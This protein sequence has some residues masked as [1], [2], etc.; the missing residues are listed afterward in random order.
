[1]LEA[2]LQRV[3]SGFINVF[4]KTYYN[5]KVLLL[6][7]RII[8]YNLYNDTITLKV[9]LLKDNAKSYLAS[10]SGA[11]F[12]NVL[13]N[14]DTF[15]RIGSFITDEFGNAVF[16]YSTNNIPR[17][18]I[19]TSQFYATVDYNASTFSSTLVRVNFIK[20]SPVDL[21]VELL[22]IILDAGTCEDPGS[23]DRSRYLTVD[24]GSC[25]GSV[26]NRDD[27]TIINREILPPAAP[28]LLSPINEFTNSPL[29]QTLT[30]S[31][32]NN[33]NYYAVET[34]VWPD[35]ASILSFAD[36]ISGILSYTISG[37]VNNTTYYW[38][39]RATNDYGSSAWSTAWYFSTIADVPNVPTL[40]SPAN[41]ATGVI[42][43][44]TL[45][46][47]SVA[48]AN[49]YNT[50]VAS[51][52]GFSSVLINSTGILGTSVTISD[53]SSGSGYYWR[54]N[55]VGDYGTSAWSSGWY[56]T[57][58]AGQ[59]YI[60]DTFSG[61]IYDPWWNADFTSANTLLRYPPPSGDYVAVRGSSGQ[62]FLLPA[63]AS[64]GGD[65][66]LRTKVVFGPDSTGNVSMHIEL[67]DSAAVTKISDLLW[68]WGISWEWEGSVKDTA[69]LSFS[70]YS[71][72]WLRLVRV[73]STITAYYDGG[74][75]W[76]AM[77]NPLTYSNNV[78]IRIDGSD[79]QG[80]GEFYLMAS[81]GL[82]Y[83]M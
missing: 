51:D 74:D 3:K 14:E 59:T 63:G 68:N 67:F 53:L 20:Y 75:E 17:K 18:D 42:T 72:F 71:S 1:M 4:S 15:D 19:N 24:A 25:D 61:G 13:T 38:R 65:F 78:T 48:Y 39:A 23:L 56:F 40:I 57:T 11:I 21:P 60:H 37:L 10:I 80:V 73:G 64:V 47:N 26:T 76:V 45:S 9:S 2:I 31:P 81:S 54:A 30:W 55:A 28:I 52:S 7:K 77:A 66:D 82:P 43:T 62:D 33:A 58:Y 35:F 41:N 70:A 27:F 8:P 83:Y 46:W 16:T 22:D 12:S 34:S 32:S 36:G 29:S 69:A 50:Q 44:P 5:F 79:E 49:S 6:N